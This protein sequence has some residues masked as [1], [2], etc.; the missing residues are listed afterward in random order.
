[1][2]IKY[3]YTLSNIKLL[4]AKRRLKTCPGLYLF[5]GESGTGKTTYLKDVLS[6][7]NALW[8]SAEKMKEMMLD[9]ILEKTN[10][11]VVVDCR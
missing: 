7:K 8:L 5:F 1:M 3:L 4:Y 6:D 10:I 9:D 11:S 2:R